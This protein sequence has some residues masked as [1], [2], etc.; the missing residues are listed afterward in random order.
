MIDLARHVGLI[1][2]QVLFVTK[3]ATRGVSNS[4]ATT[5]AMRAIVATL[6]RSAILIEREAARR[7]GEAAD[8]IKRN[9]ILAKDPEQQNK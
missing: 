4:S 3:H 5:S 8:Q 2:Q 9:A 1:C 7:E 6:R